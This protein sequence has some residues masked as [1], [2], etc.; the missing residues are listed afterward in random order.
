M[1]KQRSLGDM[2]KQEAQKVNDS[3]VKTVEAEVVN[4]AEVEEQKAT[5]KSSTSEATETPMR[6]K[7]PTKADLEVQVTE[8]TSQVTE[9]TSQIT[10]LTS[11]LQTSRENERTL[12]EKVLHLQSEVEENGQ[13][14]A[15]LQEDLKRNDVKE[16]LDKAQKA[17][18]QLSETNTKLSE[19]NS[20]LMEEIETLKKENQELKDKQDQK[21]KPNKKQNLP[22]LVHRPE[23]VKNQP[24]TSSN[25]D[26]SQSTW[27]L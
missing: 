21:A 4:S 11:S 25:D 20:K 12:Q 8:L 27:L 6:R 13:F 9:L 14:I 23:H 17:A 22:Q 10:E 19:T 7:N 3:E 15:R 5:E 16:E 1:A 18:F 2:V 26:F 24:K